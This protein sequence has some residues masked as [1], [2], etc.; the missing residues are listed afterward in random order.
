MAALR[1]LRAGGADSAARHCLHC[2]HRSTL[3]AIGA[4]LFA[5][6]VDSVATGNTLAAALSIRPCASGGKVTVLI[7]LAWPTPEVM[8][9][10]LEPGD[11]IRRIRLNLS[12]AASWLHKGF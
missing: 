2:K 9:V 11:A 5:L 4:R 8:I 3:A 12:C 10:I 6:L 1:P 7:P